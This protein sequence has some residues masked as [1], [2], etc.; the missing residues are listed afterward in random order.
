MAEAASFFGAS[1]GESLRVSADTIGSCFA[2]GEEGE[3]VVET[4]LQQPGDF[5][6]DMYRRCINEVFISLVQH[7]NADCTEK[8][9]KLIEKNLLDVMG[10]RNSIDNIELLAL[11]GLR[12][13]SV[14]LSK[15][16]IEE[17][18]KYFDNSIGLINQLMSQKPDSSA[19]RWDNCDAI[20]NLGMICMDMRQPK[21]A[22]HCFDMA[23]TL[24]Q[25]KDKTEQP[26]SP[27]KHYY[28]SW[29]VSVCR[30]FQQIN[31]KETFKHY[32]EQGKPALQA[33]LQQKASFAAQH[34][35]IVDAQRELMVM[36]CD[37]GDLCHL[38]DCNDEAQA[39]YENS[40]IISERL[41]SKYPDSIEMLIAPSMTHDRIGKM[42][43]R[44]E[45]KPKR[46]KN[47][48][49]YP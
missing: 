30:M 6:F 12:I 37:F 18:K 9:I 43:S 11:T 8:Y 14:K 32:F 16:D 7:T 22:Q 40:L 27:R 49:N 13:A 21:A 10:E 19:F 17:V 36:Y 15:N 34:P 31:D 33:S 45:G 48:S 4:L 28:A 41:A 5:R 46:L 23:F 25:E 35:E 39:A 2:S 20:F 3:K 26:D 44:F 42:F 47:I 29:Y 24:L 38:S 1:Q